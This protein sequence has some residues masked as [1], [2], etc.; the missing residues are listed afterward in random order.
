[1]IAHSPGR[2]PHALSPGTTRHR[3]IIP[4]GGLARLQEARGAGLGLS[5]FQRT[6]EILEAA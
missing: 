5:R 6:R 3:R 1:V 2:M 4:T